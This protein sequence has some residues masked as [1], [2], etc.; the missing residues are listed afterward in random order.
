LYE[1]GVDVV[2]SGH[3]HIYERFA[4]QDDRGRLDLAR[5]TRQFTVGTGGRDYGDIQ[6]VAAN[7]EVRIA[8]TFG[9]LKVTLGAG[10]YGWQFVPVAGAT[11]TDSGTDVCR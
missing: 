11:A 7:S 1:F 9:V 2:F 3:D 6:N 8:N 5:G 4:P 10:S